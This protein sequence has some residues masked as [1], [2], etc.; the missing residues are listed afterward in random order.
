[1]TST[2][3]RSCISKGEQ[4]DGTQVVDLALEAIRRAAA[5]A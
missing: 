5:K 3:F 4:L 1:L 2:E